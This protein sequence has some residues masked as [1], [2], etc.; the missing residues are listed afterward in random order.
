LTIRAVLTLLFWWCFLPI[1]NP[2]HA[3]PPTV[4]VIYPEVREPYRTVFEE[5]A[6]GMEQELGS[7]V[8]HYQLSESQIT[9]PAVLQEQLRADSIDVAVTLGRAGVYV[10]KS[11][12][13]ALPI[14]IG[15]TVLHPNEVPSNATAIS[16]TPAPEAMFA[17]L[18]Q[19]VPEIKKITVIYDPRQSAW[20]VDHAVQAAKNLGLQLNAQATGNLK[21][22]SDLYRQL[23]DTAQDSTEALWLPR[24]NAA[25]DEQ[26]LLPEILKEAWEKNFVVFSSNLEHVRKGVL[27]SLFPDNFGMGRSLANL[28]LRKMRGEQTGST[29]QLLKDLQV[30]VNLR[31]ADHLGLRISNQTRR[32]FA[33]VFPTP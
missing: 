11:L 28:A 7:A 17:Y 18:K 26:S 13:P 10:A 27:F 20:E 30:A 23:L 22:S 24:E 15:A 33:L 19:L 21:D 8:I 1:C 25:M 14:V 31:T 3:K 5:I 6:R 12:D 4:G 29:V 16:L 2:A 9:N 32:E